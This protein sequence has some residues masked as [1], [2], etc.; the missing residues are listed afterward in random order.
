MNLNPGT[1]WGRCAGV[2][3]AGIVRF[4]ELVRHYRHKRRG[5]V[6]EPSPG[7]EAYFLPPSGLAAKVLRTARR[8]AVGGAARETL[9][10]AVSADQLLVVLIHRKA[11]RPPVL[12]FRLSAQLYQ[13]CSDD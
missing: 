5:G 3:A 9:P 7:A 8:G 4:R 6:A 11:R 13:L 10:A 1:M 2:S 12:G